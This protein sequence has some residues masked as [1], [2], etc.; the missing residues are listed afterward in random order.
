MIDTASELL[1]ETVTASVGDDGNED[2]DTAPSEVLNTASLVIT[3]IGEVHKSNV[4]CL[5]LGKY[6]NLLLALSKF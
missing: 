5:A 4:L 2:V 1:S 6:A 3:L